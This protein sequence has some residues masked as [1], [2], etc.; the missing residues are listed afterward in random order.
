MALGIKDDYWVSAK[1]EKTGNADAVIFWIDY[2]CRS[3]SGTHTQTST[4]DRFNVISTASSTH[5]QM[6]RKLQAKNR[7]FDSKCLF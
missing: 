4:N 3:C 1:F 6:V 7:Y 2:L 5:R